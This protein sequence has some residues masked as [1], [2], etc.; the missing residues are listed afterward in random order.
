MKNTVISNKNLEK[1][2]QAF[3]K[4]GASSIHIISDFDAT[5]TYRFV[6]NEK[7]PSIISILRNE[8]YLTKDYPQKA[9]ALFNKYHPLE[10]SLKLSQTKKKK[11]MLEW[12]TKHYELLIKSKLHLK[13]IHKAVKSNTIKLRKG[14]P[15]LLELLNKNNIPTIILSATG[16]GGESISQ[17]L[18]EDKIMYNNIHIISNSFKFDKEGYVIEVNKPII[19]SMNK[20]E[21]VIAKMP[22]FSQIKNRKNV[23][24]LG[25]KIS[26]IE[27]I[28][29]FKYNNILKIGFLN[30]HI[31]EQL[32][33]F[34]QNYD[35]IIK[36]DSDM[37][38][39]VDLI[40]QI[41]KN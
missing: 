2:K 22:F 40:K 25:D 34:K 19:H 3:I 30:E 38:Y 10:I 13:D 31:E 27:M 35:I 18:L 14:A 1:I 23:I 7:V 6:D 15:E 28:T 24:L 20:D 9:H 36:N 17:K 39:V 5:L 26:D 29:G 11:D 4:D 33:Q 21:T 12:W 37:T 16:L 41:L 8:G 32:D